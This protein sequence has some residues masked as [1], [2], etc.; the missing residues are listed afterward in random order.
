MKLT[1]GVKVFGVAAFLF[2]Q[3][4][5]TIA[6]A[7]DTD[8]FLKTARDSMKA[9][10]KGKLK[11]VDSLIEKQKELIR[12]GIEGCLEFAEQSPKDAKM[13]QL[14]VLNS[15]K[16]QNLTLDEIEKEWREGS[17]LKSHG[18]DVDKY[19][20]TDIQVNYFDA[21]VNPAMVIIALNEYKK[22]QDPQLLQQAHE[23]LS[24]VVHQ[25][26]GMK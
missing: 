4:V 10:K 20:Q 7:L 12:L 24:E 18:I 19:A 13:M 8:A 26:E 21:I 22:S 25:V 9:V 2:T 6:Y 11:D 15:I 5:A 3:S 14:I 1:Y 17:Y 23:R 16:M